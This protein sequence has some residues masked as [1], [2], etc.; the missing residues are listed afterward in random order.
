M[1]GKRGVVVFSKILKN[2]LALGIDK[3]AQNGLGKK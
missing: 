3:P 2:G 1:G